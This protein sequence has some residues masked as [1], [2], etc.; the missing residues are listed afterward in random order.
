MLRTRAHLF[1]LLL[2]IVPL[3]ALALEPGDAAP[4]FALP[5]L[6]GADSTV[7]LDLQQ[8]RGKVVYLD[9]WASWCP[10]C[11][12]SMP[13][14]DALRNR[15]VAAGADF[16]V[17]AINVDSD[18]EDGREF[19]LDSPVQYVVLSDP[20]G[21]TP[22]LYQVKGMPTSFLLDAEG[23]IRLVHQGFKASDIDMIESEVQ[24]LLDGMP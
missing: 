9:F 22:K 12:V 15:L 19:L 11:L 17:L 10:P 21:Q 6:D 2:S 16:E 23:T 5:G 7:T 14:L 13:L 3:H 18:P 20:K 4:Q 24:K 1:T 8:Y